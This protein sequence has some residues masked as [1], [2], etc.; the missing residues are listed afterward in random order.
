MDASI[1]LI[2]RGGQKADANVLKMVPQR[3]PGPTNKKKR[4]GP[5]YL[6]S[7]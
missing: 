7:S 1:R 6:Y 2:I 3:E 5:V 4:N